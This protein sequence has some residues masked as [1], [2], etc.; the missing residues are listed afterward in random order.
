MGE[1]GKK[2]LVSGP[3]GGRILLVASVFSRAAVLA[4]LCLFALW[5]EYLNLKVGY[6]SARLVEL[7]SGK[8]MRQFY[9]ASDA[10]FGFFG[11]PVE[12]MQSN[13]GMTWSIRLGGLTFTDPVAGMSVLVR[14]RY[15]PWEFGLG[16]VVP[17]LLAAVFGRVFCTYVCPAS[18]LFFTIARIRRLLGKFF[19][20]PDID[21]GRGLAWGILI[22]G[23]IAALFLRHG[24]WML[25]LPYF[26]IGQTIFHGL[27][28]GTLSI[29]VGAVAVFALVDLCL[30]RNFTC[31]YLCPTGRLLG[32]I[33]QKARVTV[34]RDRDL[35]L[36]KCTS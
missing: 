17:L 8:T 28:F 3:G 5:T 35:C 4:L 29:A 30:G 15:L 19:Y 2:R 31:R 33:G 11:D 10:F 27:A 25:L 24:I 23:L 1:Q 16:L 7:S 36:D 32:W 9:E 12:V 26:G 14:N 6:N 22:G 34:R 13:G 20:F 21:A 18:L